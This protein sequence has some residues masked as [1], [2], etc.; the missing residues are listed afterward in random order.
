MR[1]YGQFCPVAKAAEV[2][3]ER[4]TPLIIRELGDGPR[5]FSQL[6]RGVPL[7]SPSLLSRRLK[8][9]E[10]EGVVRRV[11]LKGE[12]SSAYSLTEAGR[13]FVPL[14]ETLGVWGMRWSRRELAEHEIDMG[15]LLWAIEKGADPGALGKSRSVVQMAFD[16]QPAHKA[17]WWFVNENARCAL[18]VDDPG[19]DVDL[20]VSGSL[21][22]VTYLVRG[23]VPLNRALEEG[24]VEVHGSRDMR[25]RFADWLN[26]GPL[27]S[28]ASRR[29]RL[30]V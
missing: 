10:A 18:C 5:R 3:C 12:S 4:W 16:D 7:M 24:R 22:D 14:V 17:T 28:V 15:L 19:F 26:L 8:Q 2:F 21:E 25:R 6:Q 11:H 9:L 29:E 30:A 23:D 1:S 13:E 20:Y 27:A